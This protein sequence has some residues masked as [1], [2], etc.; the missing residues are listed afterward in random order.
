[1]NLLTSVILIQRKIR[2]MIELKKNINKEFISLRDILTTIIRNIESNNNII[3]KR[4]YNKSIELCDYIN[5]IIYGYPISFN[6]SDFY[7]I[8]KF[9]I[10]HDL[11]KIKLTL[12]QITRL[13]GSIDIYQSMN[14]YLDYNDKNYKN[15]NRYLKYYNKFF[16]TTKIESYISQNDNNISYNL[17]TYGKTK[18][19]TTSITLASYQIDKPTINKYHSIIK[20]LRIKI[21]GVKIY[22]PHNNKLLVLF[23]YFINDNINTYQYQ[24]VFINKY[25]QLKNLFNNLDINESYR[26]NYINTLSISEFCIHT[27]MQIGNNCI[28]KYNDFVKFKDKIISKIVK[29]FMISDNKRRHQYIKNLLLDTDDT[30]SV[31]IANLLIDLLEQKDCKEIFDLFHWNIKKTFKLNKIQIEDSNKIYNEVEIPLDK[32]I[33]L[34]KSSKEIKNK[35]LTKLKEIN[36]SK[37]EGNSKATQYLEGLLKVPFGIYKHEIIRSKLDEL[38]SHIYKNT[39]LILDL[40]NKIQEDY[41]LNDPD[42]FLCEKLSEILNLPENINPHYIFSLISKLDNWIKNIGGDISLYKYLDS[43]LFS[44]KMSK[45]FKSSEIK[46]LCDKYNIKYKSKNKKALIEE[47]LHFKIKK[48]TFNSLLKQIKVKSKFSIIFNINEI[49]QIIKTVGLIKGDIHNYQ[50]EQSEYF[51][52]IDVILDDAIYGLDNAK[53]QIKRMLGQWINGKNEGYVFGLEGPPGTGKTTLAKKGIAKCL[54]DENG[55]ERPFVFIALGGSSN[56]STLEGHNYTYVGSTWGRIVDGLI[57]SKCMNPI[58]YIDE[59]DKISKTEHGKEIVGILTH[60]TDKSQNSGFS[61]RYFSGIEFDLSKCLIIFSYNNV[62]MIDPI[63]LDRIHRINIKSLNKTEKYQVVLKYII[64]EILTTIGYTED[65]ITIGTDSIEYIIDTYTYEAGVRKLKEKLFEIYREINLRSLKD[66]SVIPFNIDVDF[67]SKLFIDYPKH[68]NI[69]IYDQ[70][71]VGTINGLYATSAGI[72]GI[73]IIE[74]TFFPST[75]FFE[76]KLTGQQGDVMKESMDVA[77]TLALKLIPKKILKDLQ[78]KDPK[79]GI[80]I[81]CPA[82][83][84]KKDGPSAGTA[85]TVA[86]LSLL[87]NLPIRN[88][89]GI[90]GEINLNG[91]VLPIGGLYS[92]T[93]GAKLAGITQVLC[94]KKNEDALIKIR[95]ENTE[96]ENDNFKITMI[97]TIYDAIDKILIFPKKTNKSNYFNKLS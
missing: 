13:V 56:G 66:P 92:K 89:V 93:E 61:D 9:K 80:H 84:T 68:D 39:S 50:Q 22:I 65:D 48:K 37:G 81:H 83:G 8:S 30:N 45:D 21:N 60:L 33:H 18:N 10:F 94:P 55:N 1:M 42:L 16:R 36:S 38:K 91:R 27:V 52:N 58:I 47:L 53:I 32:R 79:L 96:M 41:V 86:L 76:L 71:K 82:G 46:S 78:S 19:K 15:Y 54:H 90:T 14:L 62:N 75:N 5:N 95:K 77:K 7:S 97:E 88:N 35:A 57:T 2:K 31:Y 70:P 20:D 72:G 59:L 73:T 25:A 17:N 24:P 49:T 28:S 11:A 29:E 69:K 87:C 63:L 23:G 40:I 51:K 6:I 4:S 74:T 12:I 34:M 85:I 44:K 26:N 3:T 64:P 67:V 43:K